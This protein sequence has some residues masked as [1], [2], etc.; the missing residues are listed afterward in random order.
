MG[1]GVALLP[2]VAKGGPPRPLPKDQR[3]LVVG[4]VEQVN[5]ADVLIRAEKLR[6]HRRDVP[7]PSEG[8]KLLLTM[9]NLPSGIARRDTIAVAAR[10]VRTVQHQNAR[11]ST[12]AVR[13]FDVIGVLAHSK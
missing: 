5:E 4:Q 11:G 2:A 7:Q 6:T 8:E 3:W 12:K 9:N 13:V 1:L 10:F